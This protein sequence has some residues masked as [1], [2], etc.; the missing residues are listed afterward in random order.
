MLQSLSPS[1]HVPTFATSKHLRQMETDIVGTLLAGSLVAQVGEDKA[2]YMSVFS[3]H[4]SFE[5]EHSNFS[6]VQMLKNGIAR[7][8]I[9]SIEPTPGIKGWVTRT[10]WDAGC[11]LAHTNTDYPKLSCAGF[12]MFQTLQDSNARPQSSEA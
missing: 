7:M 3:R 9:Q 8:F 5:T 6:H 1:V 12:H 10:A 4:P 11:W 2:R